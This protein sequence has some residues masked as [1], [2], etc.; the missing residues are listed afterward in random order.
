MTLFARFELVKIGLCLHSK[1]LRVCLIVNFAPCNPPLLLSL[2]FITM[3]CCFT[4]LLYH[5]D[6]LN[7]AQTTSLTYCEKKKMS[8]YPLCFSVIALTS[9]Q[10]NPWAIYYTKHC[11]HFLSRFHKHLPAVDVVPIQFEQCVSGVDKEF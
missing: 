6:N 2:C 10:I 4:V 5:N 7:V 3:W 1:L 11:C 8:L 9:F